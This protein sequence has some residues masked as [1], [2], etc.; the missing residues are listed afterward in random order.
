M[1]GT[2]NPW[3]VADLPKC[4]DDWPPDPWLYDT[5]H[6]KYRVVLHEFESGF[7]R[8]TREWAFVRLPYYCIPCETGVE[9]SGFS[10]GLEELVVFVD[11]KINAALIER[12][13]KEY[14]DEPS[15]LARVES[16]ECDPRER[17]FWG[18]LDGP[19]NFCFPA[20][21][22]DLLEPILRPLKAKAKR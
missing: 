17:M 20:S 2:E 3:W 15:W 9:I 18:A 10:S 1:R 22:L 8:G 21:D 6:K 7:V 12:L 13:E 11:P 14:T 5:Y 16:G 19:W 4:N